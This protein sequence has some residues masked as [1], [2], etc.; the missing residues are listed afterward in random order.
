MNIN[1][2]ETVKIALDSIRSNLMRTFLT[3]LG[4]I[5]GIASV[6]MILGVGNGGKDQIMNT[7]TSIGSNIVTITVNESRASENDYLTVDDISSLRNNISAISAATTLITGS[8]RVENGG[9]QYSTNITGGTED[10]GVIYGSSYSRGRFFSNEEHAAARPVCVIQADSAQM[11]FGSDD[12]IGMSINLTI[13]GK[14]QP[15]KIIGV[16]NPPAGV[17]TFMNSETTRV[18]LIMPDTTLMYLMGSNPQY[19]NALIQA[20]SIDLVDAAGEAAVNM[21]N[22]RHNNSERNVYRANS[23]MNMLEQVNSILGLLTSFIAAVGAIALIVG[24]IGVMNIMLVS[25]TERTREIGIRK[26]LGART[27]TIM[28]QFL[29]ESSFITFIGGLIGLALG[30]G[31]AL[32]IGYFIDV[33]PIFSISNIAISVIFSVA[34]GL[35]FGIYPAKKA[36]KLSP[37]E[38]LRRD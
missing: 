23:M 7:M 31:G 12:I 5:I 2:R 19:S 28:F 4:I 17:S 32:L 11:M 6:I 15:I 18:T 8:G 20:S 37:I 22:T 36:A 26:S 13:K 29:T 16:F 14:V 1:I 25:V 35:F 21:L 9:R 33:A 3:M 34:V 38:A 24:G 30:V 10:L 27:G